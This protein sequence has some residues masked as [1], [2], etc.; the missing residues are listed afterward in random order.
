MD[1][2]DQTRLQLLPVRNKTKVIYSMSVCTYIHVFPG[3]VVEPLY[4]SLLL[5]A[6]CPGGGAGRACDGSATDLPHPIFSSY[7]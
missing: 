4:T 6:M 2:K 3:M 1:L 7:S 5:I